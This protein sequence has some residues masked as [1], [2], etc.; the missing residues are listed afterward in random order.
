MVPRDRTAGDSAGGRVAGSEN[1]SE[2]VLVCH[3]QWLRHDKEARDD[4]RKVIAAPYRNCSRSSLGDVLVGEMGYAAGHR[5]G[6]EKECAHMAGYLATLLAAAP[7]MKNAGDVVGS[8]AVVVAAGD[9]AEAGGAGI[10]AIGKAREAV[11]DSLAMEEEA[12]G[13]VVLEGDST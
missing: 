1:W 6:A 12:P 7:S 13:E 2:V 4:A 11:V 5:E 8:R 10:A 9:R 3:N